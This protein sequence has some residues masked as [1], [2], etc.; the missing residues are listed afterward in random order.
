MTGQLLEPWCLE[1]LVDLRWKRHRLHYAP[2]FYHNSS[3]YF[4]TSTSQLLSII[5]IVIIC[6]H[7]STMVYC[8]FPCL[9]V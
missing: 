6:L 5:A 4:G 3:S 8:I 7:A 1:N 9:L 2:H